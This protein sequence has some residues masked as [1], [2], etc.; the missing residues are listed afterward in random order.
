MSKSIFKRRAF[1]AATGL[2]L[3]A[4]AITGCEAPAGSTPADG[5]A[6]RYV[7]IVSK[8]FQH[9]F[10][11]AVKQGADKAAQEFNVEVSFEGPNTEKDV[12]Q[13][14]QMLTTAIGKSPDAV[15]FAALD[16]Q[17]ATPLLEDAKS[18]KIP[19]IA[20]DSGVDSTIPATTA[21][22]D[23]KAAAAEAAKHLAELIGGTGEI[24]IIGHDQTSKSGNDRRD[25]FKEYIEKNHPGI[26]IVAIQYAGGDQLLSADAA[27]AIL[28]ANPNLKGMYGTNEGSAI[29]VVKAVEELGLKGKLTVVG[30]DSGKAQIDAIRSGLMAGA[31]TQNP[32][33]IGYETVKAAVAA[34][35]GEKL[36]EKID[37]GFY[38]YDSTNI[39]SDQIKPNLYQ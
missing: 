24:A 13:Q 27:K 25:G 9:Q 37:T 8:G 31:V 5:G 2:A 22:T 36:P 18:K 11:Q 34:I 19:V 12:D 17:A 38:W 14:I 32:V 35:K 30:F 16:S 23:N 7:A 26:K 33:G 15:G 28:T 10:W 3:G 1:I 6:K 20:F 21:S 29:G 39:D 4:L